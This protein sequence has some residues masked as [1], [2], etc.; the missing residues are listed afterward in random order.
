LGWLGSTQKQLVIISN[1]DHNS[2]MFL[3]IKQY[4]AAIQKFIQTTGS[5]A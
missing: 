1:A 3:G 4:F 5:V 2:V